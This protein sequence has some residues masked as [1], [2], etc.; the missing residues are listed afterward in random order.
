MQQG[1]PQHNPVSQ[2][3]SILGG[4]SKVGTGQIQ[5]KKKGIEDLT[6]VWAGERRMEGKP[7]NN[8]LH[9]GFGS[10]KAPRE[11]KRSCNHPARS[12]PYGLFLFLCKDFYFGAASLRAFLGNRRLPWAAGLQGPR[13]P[14]HEQCRKARN[15][16]GCPKTNLL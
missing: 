10:C 8:P 4:C 1:S 13:V 3:H 9:Q 7:H 11:A 16:P 14:P 6:E 2:S 5:K 12:Y 15:S